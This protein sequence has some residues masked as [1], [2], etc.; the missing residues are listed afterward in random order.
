VT[1]TTTAL[2]LVGFLAAGCGGGSG[3]KTTGPTTA[4]SAQTPSGFDFGTNSPLRVSAFGDS[5]TLGELGT[6]LRVRTADRV[7]SNNYPNNLQAMLRG[8]DSGWRVV[9]RGRGG[10]ETGQ[11]VGRIGGVLRADRPGFVLIMEGTNDASEDRSAGAI[12]ANLEAMI[13]QVQSSHSIP[14]VATIP[15][16]FRNDANAQNIISQA[17]PMIRNMA[18]A[19]GVVLAEIFDGMNDPSLFSTPSEGVR[20]PL[21]P[22]ERGYAVMAGIWFE[23]MQRAIPRPVAPPGPPPA[24]GAPLPQVPVSAKLARGR[25]R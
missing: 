4:P 13:N 23:A 14:V 9:N 8:L 12:V 11:G 21:H 3:S 1:R 22:N 5:I 7:T 10:E 2:L 25:T 18:Q 15:P 24:G 16:N 20:D 17:N 19:R 6:K